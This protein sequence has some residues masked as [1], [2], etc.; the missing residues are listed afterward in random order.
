MKKLMILTM[1]LM[2]ISGFAMADGLTVDISAGIYYNAYNL[3]DEDSFQFPGSFSYFR[4]GG[5]LGA[6]YRVNKF[7]S[8]GGELGFL[9]L[10][11]DYGDG[12]T[13]LIDLPM[14]VYADISLGKILAFRPYGGA[15]ML[16]STAESAVYRINPELGARLSLGGFY[17]DTAY[18]FAE[19]SYTRYGIGFTG[20][21]I[22]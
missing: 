6:G 7:L 20:Y 9:Y 17:I 1:L 19:E 15:V 12:E 22:D 8:A 16:H 18:V 4:A 10:T 11:Y 14:H 2:L 21:L 5:L 3:R 13:A